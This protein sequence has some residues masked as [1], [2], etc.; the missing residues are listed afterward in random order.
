MLPSEAKSTTKISSTFASRNNIN[1]RRSQSW[2]IPSCE[3]VQENWKEVWKLQPL[4]EKKSQHI[5]QINSKLPGTASIPF[6]TLTSSPLCPVC[7]TRS[8]PNFKRVYFLQATTPALHHHPEQK[9][10]VILSITN[11]IQGYTAQMSSVRLGMLQG[12]R[13][14]PWFDLWL[15][16]WMK[17][18][19]LLVTWEGSVC[20]VLKFL[21]IFHLVFLQN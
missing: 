9:T 11:S 7:S 15:G 8:L 6:S 19:L 14:T 10:A 1:S 2:N 21:S 4:T 18:L 20:P 17:L 3:M 13:C 12:T 5:L 16:V